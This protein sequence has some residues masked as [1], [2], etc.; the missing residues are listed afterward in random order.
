LT[1]TAREHHIS[2]AVVSAIPQH[3]QAVAAALA[4]LPDTEV[5]NIA[6]GKIVIVMEGPSAGVI[7]NRLTEIALMDHVLSASLVYEVIETDGSGEANHDPH[8]T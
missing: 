6:G 1:D 7:G 8:E 4:G 5:H 3:A 2:S